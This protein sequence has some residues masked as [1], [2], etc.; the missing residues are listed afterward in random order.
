MLLILKG[1]VY[2]KKNECEIIGCGG[3]DDSRVVRPCGK[4]H[5]RTG[6]GR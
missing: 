6:F 5:R 3:R 4:V 2:E 1:E